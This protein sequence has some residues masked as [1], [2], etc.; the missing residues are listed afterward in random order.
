MNISN[1]YSTLRVTNN[2]GSEEN[3]K[4]SEEQ[5]TVR[6]NNIRPHIQR[7]HCFTSGVIL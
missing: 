7:Q 3:I 6:G 1:N 2:N 5:N 4:T